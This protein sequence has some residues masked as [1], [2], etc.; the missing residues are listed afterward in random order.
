M[1]TSNPF[2]ISGYQSPNEF[3]DRESETDRIREA[4][5]NGRNLTLISWR[6]MGKTGLI[7]HTFHLMGKEKDLSFFYVDL[8]PTLSLADFIREFSK[9]VIGKLDSPTSKIIKK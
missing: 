5:H 8:L 9:A 3:C 4:I 7:H 2:L 1:N 6:R